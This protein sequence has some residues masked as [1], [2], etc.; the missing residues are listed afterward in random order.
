MG[1]K[2]PLVGGSPLATFGKPLTD[3]AS[4][5]GTWHSSAH[6]LEIDEDRCVLERSHGT[7]D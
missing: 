4:G 5:I 7:S 2:E 3:P 1:T 6:A